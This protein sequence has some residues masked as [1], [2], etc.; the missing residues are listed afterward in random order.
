MAKILIIEDDLRLSRMYQRVIAFEGFEVDT[1]TNGEEGL[2][3]AKEVLPSL[4]L[5]DV[6]MPRMSG[7]EVL[8][9]LKKDPKTKSIPVVMFT[10]L[11]SVKDSGEAIQKGAVKCLF[12]GDSDPSSV[13][14]TIRE[15]LGEQQK[16]EEE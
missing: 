15:I 13:I 1:A 10:N 9:E 12:K 6:M 3:K 16:K 2:Q 5:L 14:Q 11:A 7:I 8:E 4:I